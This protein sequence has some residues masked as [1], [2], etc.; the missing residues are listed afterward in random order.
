MELIINFKRMKICY[1]IAVMLLLISCEKDEYFPDEHA[2]R[3]ENLIGTWKNVLRS[4]EDSSCIVF[5]HDGYYG[6]FDISTDYATELYNLWHNITLP[7]DT[8]EGLFYTTATSGPKNTKKRGEYQEYYRTS[9]QNDTLFI[10]NS[11]TAI[12]PAIYLRTEY[13]LIFD[14]QYYVGI[15]S[16]KTPVL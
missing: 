13:Q 14:K 10:L 9:S 12:S 11:N 3:D 5:T 4:P 1:L 8:S 15:D 16:L 2:L 6:S 7:S